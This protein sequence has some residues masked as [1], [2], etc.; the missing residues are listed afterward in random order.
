M[1]ERL[2]LKMGFGYGLQLAKFESGLDA[3]RVSPQKHRKLPTLETKAL[4]RGEKCCLIMPGL[5]VECKQSHSGCRR[6]T[7]SQ[8][9]LIKIDVMVNWHSLEPEVSLGLFV[10]LSNNM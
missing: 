2:H 10:N 3:A 7:A 6:S 1:S 4:A 5:L 9:E 8:G